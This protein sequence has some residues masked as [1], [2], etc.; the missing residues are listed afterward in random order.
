MLRRLMLGLLK[1][2]GV[3]LCEHLE[4]PLTTCEGEHTSRA[5]SGALQHLHA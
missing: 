3:C 1:V 2:L 4:L 5:L